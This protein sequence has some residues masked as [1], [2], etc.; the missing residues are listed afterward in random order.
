MPK[1]YV[2]P[3]A[4]PENHGKTVAAWVM[5]LGV[6]SGSVVAALGLILASTLALVVG[7][8]VIVV[9]VLVSVVLRMMGLGQKQRRAATSA[10]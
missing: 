8:A 1:T 6:V 2:V 9:G 10:S 3:P 4:P 7:A 5:L